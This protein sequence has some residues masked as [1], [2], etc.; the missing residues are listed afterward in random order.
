MPRRTARALPVP[1]TASPHPPASATAQRRKPHG[2]SVTKARLWGGSATPIPPA[3]RR[4]HL[5]EHSLGL[6][7]ACR[8]AGGAV[9]YSL[10]SKLKK[11]PPQTQ[12]AV[13]KR[14]SWSSLCCHLFLPCLLVKKMKLSLQLRRQYTGLR[15]VQICF[16]CLWNLAESKGTEA[17]SG[18]PVISQSLQMTA[19]PSVVI[20]T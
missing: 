6:H 8:K 19:M 13:C 15:P 14:R 1:P 17:T 11:T 10:Y 3:E 20:F 5:Q 16:L 9:I 12:P 2:R 4:T 7:K 18:S